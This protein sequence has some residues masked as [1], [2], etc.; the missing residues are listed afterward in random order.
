MSADKTCVAMVNSNES[1][2]L[3]SFESCNELCRCLCDCS[4]YAETTLRLATHSEAQEEGTGE[5]EG[6]EEE[7]D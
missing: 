6:Q 2:Y 1:E 7:D 3:L 4:P 5:N